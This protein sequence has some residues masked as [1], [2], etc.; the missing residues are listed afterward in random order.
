[1]LIKPVLIFLAVSSAS[2]SSAHAYLD[3]GTGSL[4]LQAVVG[5]IAG[6]M[7]FLRT[8]WFKV[9]SIF[10]PKTAQSE[11]AATDSDHV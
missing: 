11:D 5:G 1:M 7:V 10:R 3:P 8:Y 9:T 4:I 2:L 6:A